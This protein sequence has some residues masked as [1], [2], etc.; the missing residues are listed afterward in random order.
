MIQERS[1]GYCF[2][3]DGQTTSSRKAISRSNLC[4]LDLLIIFSDV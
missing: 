3:F 2:T 1:V 4:G